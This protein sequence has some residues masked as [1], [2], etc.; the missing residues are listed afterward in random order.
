MWDIQ[1]R[2]SRGSD[3]ARQEGKE[4]AMHTTDKLALTSALEELLKEK[5][6]GRQNS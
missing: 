5:E 1:F 2:R 4:S 6:K 3:S